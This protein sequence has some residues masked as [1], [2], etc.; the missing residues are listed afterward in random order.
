MRVSMFAKLFGKVSAGSYWSYLLCLL[1][2][3]SVLTA[4]TPSR[5]K[6]L[7]VRETP[8]DTWVSYQKA[9]SVRDYAAMLQCIHPSQRARYSQYYS[10]IKGYNRELERLE[11]T[12]AREIGDSEAQLFRD[13]ARD[14][15][16]GA[17]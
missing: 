15:V 9:A 4:C 5:A 8:A 16:V 10:L 14:D 17:L 6:V 13:R 3:A 1:S 11:R 7:V 12:I 2:L